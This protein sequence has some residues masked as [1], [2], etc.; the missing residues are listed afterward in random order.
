MEEN[1]K[2][3][4]R[5]KKP[6]GAYMNWSEK[7]KDSIP[8]AEEEDIKKFELQMDRCQK[9]QMELK[10][11]AETR[12]RLGFYGQR[13]DNGQRY[14]GEETKKIPF[15]STSKKGH[16]TEW[17][18]PGM[19]RIKTP[20]GKITADQLD[21]I[22]DLSEE[23]SDGISHITTR[24]A[25]Q[26]HYLHLNDAPETMRR[27]AS[28]GVTTKEACGNSVRNVTACSKSGICQGEIFDTTPYAEALMRFLLV[29][30]DCQNFGRKIKIAFSGC[31]KD[32]CALVSMHD[33]G[34]IATTRNVNG[35]TVRGFEFWVGGGLGAI[36]HQAQL[37]KEFVTEDELLP[38]TQSVCRIFGELG[39]KENRARARIK[40]LIT[41]L[42]IEK[43]RELVVEDLKKIKPDTRWTAYLDDLDSYKENT[44]KEPS[45]HVTPL[46]DPEYTRWM[47]NNVKAQR[48][49]GY[50]MVV[51]SL[52]L[53]DI[54]ADQQR[55]LADIVRQYSGETIRATVDQNYMLRWITNS[56]LPEVYK[57]LKTLHLNSTVGE[58]IYNLTSCPGTDTCKLGISASRGLAGELAKHLTKQKEKFGPE[59]EAL[60]IKIS[61][62]FN[63]CGQHHIS[64]I[65]FYGVSRTRNGFTVPH[66]QAV[67][68]GQYDENAGA[69]GLAI[70]AIPSKNVPK[71]VDVLLQRFVDEKEEGEKF[72][73]F[74]K[75]KGKKDLK[76]TVD[77]FTTVPPHETNP[78]YYSDWG[79]P[80]QYSIKDLG[81]G[82]CA[83]EVINPIDFALEAAE[84]EVFEAQL[85]LDNKQLK[86]A[87]EL[88]YS[89][90]LQAAKGLV[91]TQI[92]HPAND[93]DDIVAEF[94]KYFV[95]TELFND[96]FAGSK[97]AKYLLRRHENTPTELNEQA[98]SQ[99]VQESHLFIEASFRC[100]D[101]LLAK[102]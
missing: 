34:M 14:D 102:N 25:I 59:V 6:S 30:P 88:A 81:V 21:V 74:I 93:A 24:Q 101:K 35:T 26:L 23:V 70:G 47:D 48:Q 5:I 89:A 27:L 17:D 60:R 53:G 52:A 40:F 76:A 12:L 29:H 96:N 46:N 43:F 51:V 20:Y 75:R 92:P 36:P 15:I 77:Q 65:G 68:G 66:F 39:E 90:M 95:E 41:S 83:G 57:A 86:K 54:T 64:D 45:N 82:E 78:E 11:F 44:V 13:Y 10:V 61:G 55:G 37:L 28:V 58:K 2:K 8:H 73:N 100:Q 91:S 98:A 71:F 63:S 72:Q 69:Y 50:S 97:F 67:L 62:C 33:I 16:D 7:L 42:G 38:T 94:K 3:K 22:A 1:L 87:D 31:K 99:S 18:A 84:R 9:D 79:D 49:E 32:P 56:D 19:V 80:R 4:L 85:E